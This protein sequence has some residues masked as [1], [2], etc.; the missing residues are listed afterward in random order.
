MLEKIIMRKCDVTHKEAKTIV[1]KARENM[2]MLSNESVLWSKELEVECIRVHQ[3]QNE[4]RDDGTTEQHPVS[5][6]ATA[7]AATAKTTYNTKDTI[8]LKV[9]STSALNVRPPRRCEYV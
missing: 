8:N 9:K 5:A 1:H 4:N 2:G 3:H 7:T 6:A